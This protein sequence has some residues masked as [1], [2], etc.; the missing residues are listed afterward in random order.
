MRIETI[1]VEPTFHDYDGGNEIYK[2]Y[3]DEEVLK[4]I[5]N[6]IDYE[7]VCEIEV[8]QTFKRTSS[9]YLNPEETNLIGQDVNIDNVRIYDLETDEEIKMNINEQ[10]IIDAI[11]IE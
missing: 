7:I 5:H 10:S 9:T 11:E 1:I 2:Y 3:N 4:L 8:I 6:N